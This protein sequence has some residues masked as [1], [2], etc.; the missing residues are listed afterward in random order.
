MPAVPSQRHQ[1]VDALDAWDRVVFVG[2]ASH[3]GTSVWRSSHHNR[4]VFAPH[5][6]G[7]KVEF[8]DYVLVYRPGPGATPAGPCACD[9]DSGSELVVQGLDNTPTAPTALTL[10]TR[11]IREAGGTLYAVLPPKG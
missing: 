11:R 10:L 1:V 6:P 9:F 4:F 8:A 3:A 2:D 5:T 7:S